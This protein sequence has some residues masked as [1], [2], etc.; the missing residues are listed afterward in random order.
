MT[1]FKIGRREFLVGAGLA[2]ALPALPAHAVVKRIV[3]AGG[4][5]TE[6]VFALGHGDTV[7]AVDTTSWFPYEHVSKLPKVGYFRSLA[8]EGLLSMQPDLILADHDAARR[9]SSSNCRA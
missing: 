1:A 7:V 2:T 5:M 4:A 8:A 9:T 6:I 3:C